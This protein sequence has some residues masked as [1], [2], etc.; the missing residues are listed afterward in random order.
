MAR[1][2]KYT[3][4]MLANAA[5]QSQSMSQL[6]TSL[7][8]RLS[9]GSHAH[10][11]RRLAAL[12]IDTTHFLGRRCNSGAGHTGGAAKKQPLERLVIRHPLQAPERAERLRTAL[13]QLGRTYV[14]EACG[15]GPE[16]NGNALVLELDH[17]NGLRYDNRPANLRF[18]CPNC[19]AQTTS[20][21]I[22]NRAYAGVA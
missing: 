4:E 18:L 5:R 2:A 15:L 14:C 17:I 9:G 7:G 1:P 8:L 11:K 13:I 20:Y 21:G 12:E 6:M 3:R 19:H 10:L 16:W 22:R